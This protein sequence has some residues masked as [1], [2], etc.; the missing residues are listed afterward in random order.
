MDGDPHCQRYGVALTVQAVG[1]LC[2]NCMLKLA[3][4]PRIAIIRIS[5]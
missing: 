3:L 2:A 1:E 5:P 4:P